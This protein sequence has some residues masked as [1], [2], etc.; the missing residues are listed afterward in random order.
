MSRYIIIGDIHGCFDELMALLSQV[1]ASEEDIVVS[2]GDLVDRGPDSPRVLQWFVERCARGR[3]V[4]LMGN[5]ERKHVRKVFSYSQEITRLQFG[6]GYD[7]ATA[8][9]ATLPYYFETA[10]CVVVHAALRPGLPLAEQKEE[11]LSG[12]VAGERELQAALGERF[13]HELYTGPKPVVFG[14]HV[15]GDQPLVERGLIYG[16]DTGACH[17][18]RLTALV[19]PGFTLHSV[20]A[21]ADHWEQTKQT[22]Q[23]AVL[24]AKPWLDMGFAKASRELAQYA[25]EAGPALASL[26]QWIDSFPALIE[27]CRQQLLSESARLLSAHGS[28]G[29]GAQVE[30]HPAKA[31]LHLASRGRLDPEAVAKR[32]A[33]PRKALEL[34]AQLGIAPAVAMPSL[35]PDRQGDAAPG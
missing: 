20:P 12:T 15:V 29:F 14:H 19:V 21:R 13:W 4:V 31:L 23:A 5:H 25:D 17:G 11:V 27:Q 8:W 2:V 32:C 3:A 9:M 24:L 30:A 10:E 22:W 26:R 28:A 6:A 33:T 1:G 18:G 7:A 16:M 34:A 35:H